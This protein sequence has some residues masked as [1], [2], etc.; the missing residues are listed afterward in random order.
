[1]MNVPHLPG[2]LG[3]REFALGGIF[4]AALLYFVWFH[5]YAPTAAEITE[6]RTY[7]TN[8]STVVG[9]L[10]S[11]SRVLSDIKRDIAQLERQIRRHAQK[12]PNQERLE[13]VVEHIY[14]TGDQSGIHVERLAQSGTWQRDADYVSIPLQVSYRGNFEG[15]VAFLTRLENS[16][17]RIFVVDNVVI[18][19]DEAG[20]VGRVDLRTYYRG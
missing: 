2:N 12:L 5:V 1:M 18:T 16:P 10:D 11:D 17:S 13:Q 6:I 9:T 3:R 14:L 7:I 19:T 15:L 20:L 8:Q 4:G